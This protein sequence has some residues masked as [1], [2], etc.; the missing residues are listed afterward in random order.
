MR[1]LGRDNVSR[2]QRRPCDAPTPCRT[3]AA[4]HSRSND[5]GYRYTQRL[6]LALHQPQS[7][8][9]YKI[10]KMIFLYIVGLSGCRYGTVDSPLD[11][12]TFGPP[13]A[14]SV[15]RTKSVLAIGDPCDAGFT[16]SPF[17]CAKWPGGYVSKDCT[18]LPNQPRGC[19][20]TIGDM[21]CP[22]S[23]E[24]DQLCIN[25]SFPDIVCIKKCSS[26]QECRP[27]YHCK[28]YESGGGCVP[29]SID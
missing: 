9:A 23:C 13:T 2:P 19:G 5:C 14:E 25:G 12:G 1:R 26:S 6:R 29:N 17:F 27:D 15:S 8:A 20:L 28:K 18:T 24:S 16:G 3:A 7:D 11:S 21:E 22:G 10:N 4:P